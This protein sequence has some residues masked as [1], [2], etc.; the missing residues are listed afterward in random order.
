MR[1]SLVIFGFAV[2][3]IG[4]LVGVPNGASACADTAFQMQQS[5]QPLCTNV[6]PWAL[7]GLAIGGVGAVA[8]ILGLATQPG[9][10]L[11]SAAGAETVQ[12]KPRPLDRDAEIACKGCGRIYLDGANA[13][14]PA[15]GQKLGAT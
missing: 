7:T 10:T 5:G 8:V 12:S 2:I 9:P 15:C 11:P 1:V 3:V 14:C 4:L 13:F 6:R